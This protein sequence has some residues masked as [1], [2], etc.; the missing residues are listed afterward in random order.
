MAYMNPNQQRNMRAC[1]VCSVV[2]TTQQF[3]TSGCPNCE[4]FLE[5]RGNIDAIQECTSQ[6]FDGLLTVSD[7]SR[8]W[9]A[10][11]Q[12]LEGYAPGVYAI[13]VEG[14][15]S[16]A[17]TMSG[18]QTLTCQQLPEEVIA[19]AEAAGVQYVPRDG[20]VSEALPTDG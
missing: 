4:P 12:R 3:Q 11:F 20:S 1:M 13:Q 15:V 2:R 17:I 18:L 5:L 7:T 8:S 14:V 19:A 16:R 10:R 6:V 9:V